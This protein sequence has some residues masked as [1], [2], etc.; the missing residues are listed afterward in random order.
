MAETPFQ[1][2]DNAI[3]RLGSGFT[4]RR[5]LAVITAIHA[6]YPYPLEPGGNPPEDIYDVQLVD[7]DLKPRPGRVIKGLY[8]QVQPWSLRRSFAPALKRFSLSYEY[9]PHGPPPLVHDIQVA[10][11]RDNPPPDGNPTVS[12]FIQGDWGVIGQSGVN[13]ATLFRD[14][15]VPLIGSIVIL[16]VFSAGDQTYRSISGMIPITIEVELSPTPGD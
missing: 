15:Y 6:R 8:A 9:E 12:A 5:E 11:D 1:Q 3:A 14:Y 16:D 10:W 7:A 4:S 13:A 2:H